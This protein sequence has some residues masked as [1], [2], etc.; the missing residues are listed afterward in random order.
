MYHL[1]WGMA[2]HIIELRSSSTNP[3]KAEAIALLLHS[4]TFRTEA[5]EEVFLEMDQVRVGVRVLIK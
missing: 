3:K 4:S 5:A 1:V 2:F